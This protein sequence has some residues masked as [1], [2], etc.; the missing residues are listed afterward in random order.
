MKLAQAIAQSFTSSTWTPSVDYLY[1]K[2]FDDDSYQLEIIDSADTT[3]YQLETWELMEKCNVPVV[4][5]DQI[6][7]TNQSD[8]DTW[9]SESNYQK[10]AECYY[11]AIKNYYGIEN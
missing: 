3:D 10:A 7:V 5:S 11:S 4:I 2:P 8:I 1:Y 6:Y 9:A